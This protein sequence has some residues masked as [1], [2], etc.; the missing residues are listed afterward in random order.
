MKRV[1]IGLVGCGVISEIYLKNLVEVSSL[2][3]VA[4][5]YDL[6]QE[7]ARQRAEQFGIRTVC[8]SF[9]EML[10]MPEVDIV[11]ILTQPDS[12]FEL[13]HRSLMAGKHT[14][15]E[16]PLSMNTGEGRQLVELG[17]EKGLMMCGAPDTV[18]G[19]GI[20]TSRKLIEDGWIGQPFS[21]IAHLLSG[22]PES[23]HPNP[24]FLYHKG[25]GPLYDAAPYYVAA[26]AY[27]LGEVE[28][29]FGAG[30]IAYPRRVITSQPHYGEMI[31]VEEPTNIFALMNFRSGGLAMLHHSYDIPA[32]TQKEQL[33][34]FGSGGTMIVPN[35]FEFGGDV[36]VK[37]NGTEEWSRI[38]SMFCYRTDCRGVGVMD[39]ADALLQKRP[40]RLNAEFGQHTLTIL[41]NINKSAEDGT[42][43]TITNGFTPTPL[44]R[45]DARLGEI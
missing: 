12:H 23:W 43:H 27:L 19:S 20:Q 15:V 28:S 6:L 7:R 29:V 11:V 21:A 18:L 22:G 36:L 17:K 1:N 42:L 37:Q 16:K 14:Y 25:A 33:E 24:A 26:M 30:R 13:C 44:M 40:P 8:E 32:T 34:I 41:E 4:A 38:S 39:M 45:I 5:A 3:N 10:Q 35:A 31:E 9:D 2:T